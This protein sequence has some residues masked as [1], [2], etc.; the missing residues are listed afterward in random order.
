MQVFRPLL[1]SAYWPVTA[2]LFLLLGTGCGLGEWSDSES[3]SAK[4]SARLRESLPTASFPNV[5]VPAA[6]PLTGALLAPTDEYDIR[7]A[8][9]SCEDANRHALR[10]VERLGYEVTG[11]HRATEAV[12]G[13]ID[14]KQSGSWGGDEP[15]SVSIACGPEGAHVAP[16]SEIP[17]CEQANK[18]MR[19]AVE[20]SGF[21]IRAFHPAS[22]SKVGRL[23]GRNAAGES[24]WVSI[25]CYIERNR[26]EMETSESSPLLENIDFYQALTDFQLGF[27]TAFNKFL[28]SSQSDQG[29]QVHVSLRPFDETD[30]QV[31][32]GTKGLDPLPVKIVV[33]NPTPRTYRL[34]TERVMLV[35]V[36]GER[37]KPLAEEGANFPAPSLTDRSISPGARVEG[38]LFYPAGVYSGA[39]GSLADERNDEREGFRLDFSSD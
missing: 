11:F 26:V 12:A 6:T 17:P 4:T 33:A 22:L 23:E 20:S 7:D 5:P 8:E 38:Y 37:V 16:R 9:M 24:I 28:G 10:A 30:A 31:V 36:S 25:T 27:Y 19:K 34:E 39:R 13:R 32:F 14:A 21:A 1:A 15:V 18:I 2:L 29:D 35:A 3:Q